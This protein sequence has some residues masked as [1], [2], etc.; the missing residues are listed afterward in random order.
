MNEQTFYPY[1]VF[2]SYAEADQAW[3]WDALLPRLE[4]AGRKVILGDRDFEPGASR[5][6][7]MERAALQSRK[8]LMV[9]SP[10]YVQSEWAAF[11]ATLV[12]TLDPA[13][14]KQRLIP[15][16]RAPCQI[17]LRIRPLVS[18]DL[19]ADDEV[20]WQRL[21]R[22]VDPNR[23]LTANPIQNLAI[24]VTG[25][26]ASLAAP[27][28][29]PQGSLWLAAGL[30]GII[31]LAGLLF[32]L[33]YDWPA[34]S[35]TVSAMVG[36]FVFLLGLL[37]LREDKDFFQRL[38]HFLGKSRPAQAFMAIVLV[39]SISLWGVVG[40][41][42]VEAVRCGDL[43]CKPPGVKRLVFGEFKNLTPDRTELDLIWTEGTKKALMAKLG[44]IDSLQVFDADN[45]RVEE[46][47][48]IE[49]DVG[50][51]GSFQILGRAELYARL[52]GPGGMY[53]SPDEHVD[54]EPADTLTNT[55]A[56]QNDLAF[57]LLKRLGVEVDPM[58]KNKIE[59]TPTDSPNALEL[60]NQ[61]V[62]LIKSGDFVAAESKFRAALKQ[63]ANYGEAYS[64]LGSALASQGKYDAAIAAYQ[65][66]IERLPRYPYFPYNLGNLYLL[67]GRTDEAL[68]SL[69]KAIS[70]DP[71]YVQ[72]Y[73]ELGNAYI[74][75]EEWVNAR[76][77]LEKGLAWNYYFAPLHKNLGRVALEQGRTDEAI[78]SLERAKQLD[79]GKPLEATYWLAEAQAAA[80][81]TAK[82]CQQLAVYRDLDP[83]SISQWAPAVMD[84]AVRLAC[85]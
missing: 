84:L 55:L 22:S 79:E 26:S 82:A 62:D 42:K 21:I 39:T 59:N 66:A 34:L 41:P 61:G 23:P 51:E 16:L 52:S 13:A 44:W 43:G 65:T 48:K 2:I 19:T 6:N 67:L 46:R 25:P 8:T 15:V 58:L 47:T 31:L 40:R 70:L 60:N 20:Q 71:S 33:L 38:S 76:R 11:E 50:I 72:A 73:N 24:A 45:F 17:E 57:T 83:N 4:K 69:E 75:R 85:P 27:G 35:A 18:V 32:L 81:D 80:G 56:L 37:G 3:V 29:H 36:A 54:R 14:R 68:S 12:Q 1:D 78:A 30:L 53:L 10:A 64:N 63:D 28:W 9:L 77:A 49:S 74:L 7:E 5:I